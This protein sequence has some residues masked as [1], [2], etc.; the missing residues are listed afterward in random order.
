[1]NAHDSVEIGRLDERLEGLRTDFEQHRQESSEKHKE[2]KAAL[3]A[4]NLKIQ[5]LLDLWNSGSL[6]IKIIAG[7]STIVGFCAGFWALL[8]LGDK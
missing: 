5:G 2:L 8:H 3:D 7:L 1:M 6:L 4:N